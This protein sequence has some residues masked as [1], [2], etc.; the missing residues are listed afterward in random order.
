MHPKVHLPVSPRLARGLFLSAVLL[1]P[2]VA[3]CASWTPQSPDT[4]V[5][6]LGGEPPRIT[7]TTGS[8][9]LA[10]AQQLWRHGREHADASSVERAAGLLEPLAGQNAQARLLLARVRQHQHAFDAALKLLQAPM[11]ASLE[12]DRALLSAS[13]LRV[14]GQWPD[15][16]QQCM[17]IPSQLPEHAL[18][19]WPILSLQ[20]ELQ[21]A[22]DALQ[23]LDISSWSLSNQHWL[24]SERAEMLERTGDDSGAL[25]EWMRAL[26]INPQDMLSASLAADLLL[27]L[28]R[29]DGA[30]SLL[31]ELPDAEAIELRRLHA[32]KVLADGDWKNPAALQLQRLQI[33]ADVH[34]RPHPRELTQAALLM[35]KSEL[36]RHWA[37]INWSEQ[38]EPIDARLLLQASAASDSA[39]AQQ[40]VRNWMEQTGFEDAR[41]LPYLEARP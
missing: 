24:H 39:D 32:R 21:A 10:Q 26:R 30:L 12:A 1:L 35:D 4:V 8:D 25:R 5:L 15:A 38:K 31:Q 3:Q 33:S 40:A 2:A 37:R 19:A 18:C 34:E 14:Q 22:L 6:D 7:D 29:P 28:Q 17:K 16:L 27:R 36:A 20:G 41:L 11:P 13:I 9:T 23:A